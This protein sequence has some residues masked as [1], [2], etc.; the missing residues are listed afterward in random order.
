MLIGLTGQIGSGKTTA[1]NIFKKLGAVVIDADLIGR[2]VVENSY[3]L[4]TSLVKTF[5]LDILDKQGRLRRKKLASLAFSNKE[6][7]E[8]LNKLVHPYLLS[9]LRQQMRKA[10][11]KNK[12]VVIDAALLLDW[13]LD[14]EMDRVLVVHAS[15][16]RRLSRLAARGIT[17]RDALARQKAQLPFKEFQR[18]ADRVIL[19]NGSKADL[20]RKIRKFISKILAQTD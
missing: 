20:E 12:L 6:N 11:E 15:L 2:E 1:A 7:H 14:K 5:G 17:R 10:L 16:E 19:N 8:I 9:Q 4:L 13:G 18:R 3:P